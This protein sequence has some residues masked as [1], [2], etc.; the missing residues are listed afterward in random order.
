MTVEE[1]N[2]GKDQRQTQINK[3]ERG[4]VKTNTQELLQIVEKFYTELY[5]SRLEIGKSREVPTAK[6]G[7]VNPAQKVFQ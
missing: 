2:P 1:K 3:N 7:I 5:R 4:E 6:K